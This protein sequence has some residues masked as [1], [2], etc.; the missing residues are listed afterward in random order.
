MLQG[1]KSRQEIFG[2]A[3]LVKSSVIRLLTALYF[4]ISERAEHYRLWKVF[5][6]KKKKSQ[7]FVIATAEE[8][9]VQQ[10]NVQT[11]WVGWGL[12]CLSDQA[13]AH[14]CHTW[15]TNPLWRLH[16]NPKITFKGFKES[17][18][19]MWS[20]TRVIHFSISVKVLGSSKLTS[21]I[22][23]KINIY[24]YNNVL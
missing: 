20:Y 15:G 16:Y 4:N 18:H 7:I 12:S 5:C 11:N 13:A 1:F 3:L 24:T 14:C 23:K 8:P 9:N 21:R 22:W 2:E 17:F 10:T 19:W 6:A